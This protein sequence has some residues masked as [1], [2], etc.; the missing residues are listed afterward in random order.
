MT[1]HN[2]LV[3]F[4]KLFW[5]KGEIVEVSIFTSSLYVFKAFFF[6]GRGIRL[7]SRICSITIIILE[8]IDQLFFS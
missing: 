1:L 8:F 5:G 4:E 7:E 3:F 6:N 2:L